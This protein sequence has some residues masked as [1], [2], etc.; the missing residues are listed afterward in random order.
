MSEN[1][2]NNERPG[3]IEITKNE[4]H[5]IFAGENAK[6]LYLWLTIHSN[7]FPKVD[8]LIKDDEVAGTLSKQQPT[9][10]V[11][12]KKIHLHCRSND[13]GYYKYEYKPD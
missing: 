8:V 11:N 6:T 5:T 13:P 12:S 3:Q 4:R 10:L 7:T 9:M 1:D 2:V